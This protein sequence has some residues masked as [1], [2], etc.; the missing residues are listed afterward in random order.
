MGYNQYLMY[1]QYLI[2]GDFIKQNLELRQKR[3]APYMVILILWI[4]SKEQSNTPTH[5]SP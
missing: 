3:K 1:N 2:G 5:P 4:K